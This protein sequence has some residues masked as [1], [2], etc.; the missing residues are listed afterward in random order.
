MAEVVPDRA[1]APAPRRGRRRPLSGL[2]LRPAT[3]LAAMALIAAGLGG[4]ALRG[5]DETVTESTRQAGVVATLEHED[6]SGTLQLAGLDQLDGRHVF[7]A[8]IERDGAIAPSSLFAAQS[9]G[10]ASAAI[11]SGLGGAD[12]VM[13][14]VE[15]RG[16][17]RAPS[18]VPLVSVPV[19]Q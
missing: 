2:F 15:P 11:P 18:T 3:G 10:T 14:T 12:R 17:S 7:Q 13:V 16:G 8:W 4:Y 19:G 9:D 1:P 6:D 5:G